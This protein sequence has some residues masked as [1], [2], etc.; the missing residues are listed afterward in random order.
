MT[1]EGNYDPSRS[2]D[3]LAVVAYNGL[4][5]VSRK[6]VPEGVAPS[7]SNSAFWQKISERGERG[8]QGQSYVDKELVPI[9]DDLATGGSANVLSAEQGKVLKQELTELESELDTNI[10]NQKKE[11]ADFKETITDQVENYKPIVINGN[12]TNAADEED[13]TSEDNLLKLKDRSALNGM[14]YVILRKNKIFTEQVKNGNTIYEIRYDTDLGGKNVTIPQNSILRFNGGHLSNGNLMFNDL[15]H[16]EGDGLRCTISGAVGRVKGEWFG[17]GKESADYHHTMLQYL[18]SKG[19]SIELPPNVTIEVSKPISVKRNVQITCDSVT[20]RSSFPKLIFPNGDGFVW[21]DK[22]WSQDNLFESVSIEAKGYCLNLSNGTNKEIRPYN[23]Y[24]STFRNLTLSSREKDCIY[25]HDN[26]GAENDRMCFQ[27][28]FDDI[29]LTAPKGCGINGV[30]GLNNFFINITDYEVS[31]SLFHNVYGVIRDCNTSFSATKH[32]LSFDADLYPSFGITLDII[33][34][35]MER[36]IAEVIYSDPAMPRQ[37]GFY[38]KLDNVSI[39]YTPVAD[40][41]FMTESNIIDFYPITIQGLTSISIRRLSFYCTEGGLSDN[42]RLIKWLPTQDVNIMVE[43]DAT[44]HTHC[45]PEG[46]TI[47]DYLFDAIKTDGDFLYLIDYEN[48]GARSLNRLIIND[49]IKMVKSIKK[50]LRIDVTDYNGNYSKGLILN[51]ADYV[52]LTATADTRLVNLRMRE[53]GGLPNQAALIMVQNVSDY[54]ITLEALNFAGPS[55]RGFYTKNGADMRLAS[56]DVAILS[57]FTDKKG[58]ENIREVYR[59]TNT[60]EAGPTSYRPTLTNYEI[61]FQYFD[62]S[63]KKPIWYAGGGIWNDATGATV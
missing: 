22:S 3:K 47:I 43:T 8:P 49:Y 38:I 12:V 21:D 37:H 27:N 50:P 52:E 54:T 42:V 44:Y 33:N 6:K 41:G 51:L 45:S 53:V 55:V 15:P 34:C 26:R 61:G 39:I 59:I 14:G 1:A 32:F 2:Y 11:I 28:I 10:A 20:K 25:A 40:K 5:W 23:L 4:S 29:Y 9:V 18:V 35:N 60:L 30:N 56:G 19:Y 62:T 13:I 17:F 36:Y 48:R 46:S 24:M 58:Q 57:C 63:L 7:E 31:E 16:I